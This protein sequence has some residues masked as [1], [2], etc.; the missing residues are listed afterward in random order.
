MT[1]YNIEFTITSTYGG[2]L[3]IEASSKEEAEQLAN[4]ELS[5]HEIDWET[6]VDN[7]EFDIQEITTC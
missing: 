1:K 7:S 3:E 6:L 5:C 4:E 2:S